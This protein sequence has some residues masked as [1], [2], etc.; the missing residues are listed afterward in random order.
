MVIVERGASY[1]PNAHDGISWYTNSTNHTSRNGPT[2]SHGIIMFF[3]STLFQAIVA[4]VFVGRVAGHG[5][6]DGPGGTAPVRPFRLDQV[7]LGDGLLQEKRDR[8]KTFLETYDERRFLVLFNNEAG[9]PNP[10]DV[11]PP[12]GWEEGGLLSGHWTGHYMTALSQAYAERKEEVFKKK[13]DW[14]VQELAACQEAYTESQSPTHPGYLGALPE[15]TVLR[16]G[17]PRFAVYGSNATTNTWAPWYT[18]HKIVRGFLDAYYNTN[19]TDALQVAV[20]MAEWSHL[21]LTIGDKNHPDYTGNLTRSDLNYMW[22]TYIA[23]EFGGANEVFA[24]IYALTGDERHL[25]TAQAFDNRQSLF[26]ASVANDDILVVTPDRNPGPKRAVRLHANTHVPQFLGY[27]RVFEQSGDSEYFTSAKNFFEWLVPNREFASGGLGGIYPGSDTN[28]ELFQNRGNIANAIGGDGAETCTTYNTLKLARNLFLHEHNAT[29]MDHYERGLLNMIAGSRADTETTED[30]QLTYFQPLRAGSSR[31]YGNT[32]TCCGGTGMESHTKYQETI[33]LRSADDSALWVNLYLP[34][35]L[36]WSEK[37]FSIKQETSFPRGDSSRFTI[38]GQ[39]KLEIKLRVPGWIRNGFKVTVNGESQ[40]L[41]GV[42][43]STYVSLNRE[44]SS[45]D[46]IDVA[47]PKSIRVERALDRP[48]TQSIL[49]G[50]VVL[51]V[52][53]TP[54]NGSLWELS[55]Y[56]H[57]KRDGDYQRAAIRRASNS[58][59]GDPLFTVANTTVNVRPYYISTESPVSTYFRRVEPTVIFGTIDTG[60]PN[61]KRNDGLPNY[62]VPVAGISSPGNDGPTFLDL[63]WDQAPFESHNAFLE[64]VTTVADDLVS[65]GVYSAEEKEFIVAGAEASEKEL[66]P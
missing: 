21:A 60:V 3:S 12:G 61:R 18:Q 23:G 41:Q 25:K 19:N 7:Q 28:P 38:E 62:D 47:L 16:A 35:T 53:G 63:V 37:G 45:G 9:R 54:S 8:I 24:E 64:A 51:Q 6:D 39:G 30:P 48:D 1:L 5:D 26:G 55:L 49:W 11:Y 10:S 50:P 58:T 29:Y 32:G 33:Y 31:E 59:A 52:V 14:M 40:E 56:K 4:A 66:Q 27:M 43:P 34:S 17:P 13:L 36:N 46:V 57:L 20:K 65:A 2:S 44:W 15:D 22:D 42:Q